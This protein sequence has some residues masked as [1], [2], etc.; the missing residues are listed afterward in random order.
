MVVVR[1]QATVASVALSSP[2]SDGSVRN[3]SL[4]KPGIDRVVSVTGGLLLASDAPTSYTAVF[5]ASNGDVETEQVEARE[6]LI[7]EPG[8]P[9]ALLSDNGGDRVP[10]ILVPETGKAAELVVEAADMPAMRRALFESG[11]GFVTINALDY[12]RQK[13]RRETSGRVAR[14]LHVGPV[15]GGG[16]GVAA[17]IQGVDDAAI[18]FAWEQE[19]S[20]SAR[21]LAVLGSSPSLAAATASSS[22]GPWLV[23]AG[24]ED[25]ARIVIAV[26]RRV[27]RR[28]GA[29]ALL[30]AADLGGA[31]GTELPPVSVR[32]YTANGVVVPAAGL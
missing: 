9:M 12:A 8:H 14:V 24:D 7:A 32:G 2:D 5:E 20:F 29:F 26:G 18:G 6:R 15:P 30:Q 21:Q 4:S 22:R 27:I 3:E 31:V 10:L 28:D 19:D 1:H 17:F 25:V 23:V 13:A 16:T 11:N